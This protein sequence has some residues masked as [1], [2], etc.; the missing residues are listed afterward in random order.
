M[1]PAAQ[2]PRPPGVVLQTPSPQGVVW[3][4]LQD[5]SEILVADQLDQVKP[6]LR[7]A[8][9][10][11]EGGL[12]A[13]GFVSYE[14]APA[15]DNAMRTRS[16]GQVPLVWFGIFDRAET[17]DRLS[18]VT[19]HLSTMEWKES[20]GA[21]DYVSSVETIRRL[22]ARGDTYQ[23]NYALRLSGDFAGDPWRLFRSLCHGQRSDC[24]AYIDTGDLIVCSASPELFFELEDG[25]IRCKPM[26]GTAPRGRSFEEDLE[27]ARWL[28][29]S[30]KNR[31]ENIMIVDMVRNDL[32]RIASPESVH[33]SRLWDLE[34]YP[35]LYQ[36]TSTVE[37]ETE[38]SSDEIFAALFPCASITGAPKIRAMQ[39]ISDLENAPR[40][41]YTGA[42]GL[43]GPGR[44]ARFN[45]AIRTI[46]VDTST[47]CATYGIGG[48]IVWDSVAAD[49]WRECHTKALVLRPP[50]ADFELLETLR[51]DPDEGVLLLDRHLARLQR[52]ATYFDYP[53][54]PRIAERE[55]LASTANLPGL[56]HRLRLLVDDRGRLRIEAEALPAAERPWRLAQATS[57]VDSHDRF[58]FHKTTHRRVYTEHRDQFPDS[59]DVL[60]WNERHEVTE[61]TLANVVVK[62]TDRL[63]T[64]PVSC[65]LL[66]G[67]F[68]AELLDRGKIEEA[69]IHLDDLASAEE[70]LLINSVRRWI[71]TRF[72]PR[73]G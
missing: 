18:H 47:R 33:V 15:F 53:F 11:S 45:V 54:D 19:G 40:G 67:T 25:R 63:L 37:A 9:E 32:G 42:I 17:F 55:L 13:G 50:P 72:D 69:I 49:E 68:R 38:A 52:S 65:G 21:S 43:L 61:S 46:E 41:V 20:Q 35:S 4:R 28:R 29:E 10:A 22:I 7:R 16:A 57:P 56:T 60:L 64:P 2:A 62:F 30:S 1:S 73:Q 71:T 66:A 24:C 51:W 26:K 39:I 12:L 58:L 14:A 44:R 34:K 23:V 3:T 27:Q 59:D 48:G 31:A 70:V 8:V 36:L 5:P 6:V